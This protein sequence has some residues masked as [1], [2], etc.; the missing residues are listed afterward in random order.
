MTTDRYEQL[1]DRARE[2]I[3]DDLTSE[4]R[5]QVPDPELLHEGKTTIV[6][7][8][9]DIL[10]TINRDADHAVPRIL[11]ELGTAGDYEDGRLT[12]KGRMDEEK[13]SSRIKSYVEAYV[14]CGECGR[15]DTHLEKQDRTVIIR[16]DA[17]GG[18]R[19]IQGKKPSQETEEEEAAVEEG[20]VYEVK[21]EDTGKKGDGV[22]HK[23]KYTI[24]VDNAAEGSVYKI[25]VDKV[26]GTLAFASIVE[27]VDT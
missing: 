6:R 17:C 11:R 4:D 21:I 14:I 25:K 23:D 18:H 7:N 3:P 15:P 19:P 27:Q 16:C 2:D 9:G 1:L 5:F 12:L 20:G 24:F 26:S 22:A 10:E 8:F 13:I